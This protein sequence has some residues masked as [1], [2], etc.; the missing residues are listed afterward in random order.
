[1]KLNES[2]VKFYLSGHPE[3]KDLIEQGM[4]DGFDALLI[5][6]PGEDGNLRPVISFRA[7]ERP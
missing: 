2:Q 3:V 6:K 4:P 7:K 1:M 5:F